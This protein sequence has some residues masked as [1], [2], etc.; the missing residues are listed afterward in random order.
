MNTGSLDV[1]EEILKDPELKKYIR[2]IGFQWEGGRQI[3]EVSRR[4]PD[5]EL[6]QTES[7][8]GHGSFDWAAGQ[9]TFNLINHFLANG[10]TRYTF[11]NA[12][13]KDN[14]SSSWGWLQ[15]ALI[16]VNSSNNTYTLTPE[17]YAA[18]H[19][20]HFIQ[21][22]SVVLNGSSA[23]DL[24]LA[25]KRPDNSIVIVAGNH[26]EK[27]KSVSM[28]IDGK[29][30]KA[31]LPARSFA[32]YI[33]AD[34]FTQLSMLIDQAQ[35]IHFT[36]LTSVYAQKLNSALEIARSLNENS[37][38]DLINESSVD[39]RDII[40]EINLSAS[41]KSELSDLIEKC[42]NLLSLNYDGKESFDESIYKATDILKSSL[43]DLNDLNSAILSLKDALSDYCFSSQASVESPVDVTM[44]IS[45]PSFSQSG[46]A[47]WII[48]N[49]ASRGDF[50][51]ANIAGRSCW[52]NWSDNFNSMEIYQE[53]EGLAPGLYSVSSYSMCGIGEITNQLTFASTGYGDSKSEII[54]V[55]NAWG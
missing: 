7:E 1:Y 31:T 10:C 17:Y 9:H 24:V 21:P 5:Y 3:A 14:G 40:N 16:Q 19:Y 44:L 11:W 49:D 54:I 45:N 30:F 26:E 53:L 46:S 23:N 13:L 8:C 55:D 38:S 22:G 50:R 15:N 33:F 29:Y 4:Y 41:V 34:Q 12:I 43:S 28:Q 35:A 2:G 6:E 48:N 39:L 47:G 36:D 20:T 25:V 27:E 42:N 18:K 37:D 51:A 52:N 32:S